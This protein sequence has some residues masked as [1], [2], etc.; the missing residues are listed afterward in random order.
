MSIG[1]KSRLPRGVFRL[2]NIG[3]RHVLIDPTGAPFV[4]LGVTHIR[5]LSRNAVAFEHR[6]AGDWRRACQEVVAN[7]KSWGFNSAGY[8]HPMEIRT[9]LPFMA[10]TYLGEIA[11]WMAGTRYPDV[12]GRGFSSAIAR[13]IHQMCSGAKRNPNLIGYYWTDTPRWDLDNTRRM[14]NDDWVS[15]IRRAP[16]DWPGKKRYVEFLVRRH[17][18]D[19][20]M[21]RAS[22]GFDLKDCNEPNAS[23]AAIDLENRTIRSD[24]DEFLRLIAR[25]YYRVAGETMELEDRKHLV[26]GDRY[27]LNDLPQSVLEEALRWI[28]VVS[29]Q[30][31]R[32]QFEQEAFDRIY[33]IAR[34]P[35]MI[36]DHAVNFPTER[37]PTTGW[38]ASANEQH[39][40]R[41]HSKYIAEAFNRPY[42]VG[43]HRCHYIDNYLPKD[44]FVMQ[45]LLREDLTPYAVMLEAIGRTNK[46]LTLN[47]KNGSVSWNKKA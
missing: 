8:H 33:K 36:C 42:I 23:Y 40:A 18:N 9:M 26:F 19:P 38:P 6:Y 7:L 4:S 34:R 39:A 30:P 31:Y 1:A 5:A 11:Y 32:N 2:G 3:G 12:F 46:E 10:E 43:Y 47:L 22:Y 24:D 41:A 20:E 28:D 25:E 14:I 17:A 16:M 45:G 29:I 13:Q 44:G 35:I 15:A 27:M 37:Y 21:F